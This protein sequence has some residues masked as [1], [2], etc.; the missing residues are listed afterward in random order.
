MQV[1]FL[2][3]MS[4]HVLVHEFC[5]RFSLVELLLTSFYA[6]MSGAICLLGAPALDV[7]DYFH[8]Y[9]VKP[10]AAWADTLMH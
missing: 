6:I 1:N 7:Q 8:L 2:I 5:K 10:V 3:T 4:F 9:E